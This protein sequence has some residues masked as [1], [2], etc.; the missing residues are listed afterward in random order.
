M[1]KR[2]TR[3]E[4]ERAAKRWELLREMRQFGYGVL[5]DELVERAFKVY[6]DAVRHYERNELSEAEELLS[7]VLQLNP[8]AAPAL[9]LQARIMMQLERYDEAISLLSRL[10][11]LRPDDAESY[12]EF[13]L[14]LERTGQRR[15]AIDAFKK[16]IKAAASLSSQPEWFSELK[17]RCELL[18]SELSREQELRSQQEKQKEVEELLHLADVYESSGFLRRAKDYLK[19]ALELDPDNASLAIRIAAIDIE[20]GNISEADRLLR[21]IEEQ[22]PDSVAEVQRLRGKLS[23]RAQ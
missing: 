1:A 4:K 12:F 17:A 8:N 15:R 21:L 10:L 6:G 19:R 23:H 13:G 7:Q 22:H 3:K 20:L 5:P 2:K 9:Q 16:A 11:E 14:A 18:E